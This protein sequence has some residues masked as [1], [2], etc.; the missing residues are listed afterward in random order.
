MHVVPSYDHVSKGYITATLASKREGTCWIWSPS[1]SAEGFIGPDPRQLQHQA[2]DNFKPRRIQVKTSLQISSTEKPE[3]QTPIRHHLDRP[4]PKAA[5]ASTASTQ[6]CPPPSKNTPS[7][8][9]SAKNDT[10]A[11]PNNGTS[12]APCGTPKTPKPTSQ[13]PS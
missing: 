8:S 3:Q 2:H 10:T 7:T 9:S 13:S 12:S 6:Q 11:I 4:F 1:R 5:T